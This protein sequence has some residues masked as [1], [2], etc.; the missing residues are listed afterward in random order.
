MEFNLITRIYDFMELFDF[1]F[2]FDHAQHFHVY[3]VMLN[4]TVT[5]MASVVSLGA[6]FSSFLRASKWGGKP[7]FYSH[8]CE[9]P[10]SVLLCTGLG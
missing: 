8:S 6:V 9:V 1:R 4:S 10:P 2:M 7:L 5:H 3:N